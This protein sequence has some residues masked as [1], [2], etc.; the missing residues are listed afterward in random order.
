MGKRRLAIIDYGIGNL[1]SV[2]NALYQID[3]D[4]FIEG[5]PQKLAQYDGVILPGVG[6]FLTAL[7]ALK[8]TGMSDALE[9]ERSRGKPILGICLGMQLMCRTS[10][11]HGIHQGLNWIDAT[12]NLLSS[13]SVKVPH[14]GWNNLTIVNEHPLLADLPDSP[15]L[16]FVHSYGV[17][18][19]DQADVLATCTHGETFCAVLAKDNVQGVQFHPEKS[20]QL[21]LKILSNF[22]G[23]L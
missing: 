12:V 20:Q 19:D 4:H 7:E 15:D 2:A 8:S 10:Y 18:C 16:Y 13:E 9:V 11:E 23:A 6:A 17:Q 3:V 1:G 22:V 5:T 14:M 21:G